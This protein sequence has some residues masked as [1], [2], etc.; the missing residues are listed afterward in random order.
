MKKMK[1]NE[2]FALSEYSLCFGMFLHDPDCVFVHSAHS[3]VPKHIPKIN[4]HAIILNFIQ[5]F[6]HLCESCF[7]HF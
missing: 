3:L 6:R 1:K 2:S 4:I 5:F 7:V